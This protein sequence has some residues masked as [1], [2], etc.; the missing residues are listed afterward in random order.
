MKHDDTGDEGACR[1]ECL[2]VNISDRSPTFAGPE[3]EPG[4]FRPT[5]ERTELTSQKM[6]LFSVASVASV[7][8]NREITGPLNTPA[9]DQLCRHR[10][11]I[12]LSSALTESCGGKKFA[13]CA[14]R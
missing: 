10:Q 3:P 6:L 9:D 14:A 13:V 5:T 4:D 1:V 2:F 11:P 7:V 12:T 8:F